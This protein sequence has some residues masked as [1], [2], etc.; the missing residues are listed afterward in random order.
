MIL[1]GSR[2][3]QYYIPDI[4]RI[5]HDW[6]FLMGV[7][8][9]EEFHAKYSKYL[10]KT[11][12][13]IS[14]YEIPDLGIVEISMFRGWQPSDH[15]LLDDGFYNHSTPFG[16]A[17]VPSLNTLYEIKLATE[18]F[19]KE[20]KHLYDLELMEP[21]CVDFT[22]QYTP[23]YQM[24]RN[25]IK[26]RLEQEN[27]VKYDFF[28][29]YHIPEYIKH[30]YLHEVIVDLIDMKLPTYVKI[31]TAETDI[32][33]TLFNKLSYTDK[34]SLMAE[35]SLVLALERWFIPQMIENGINFKLLDIFDNNNEG[36]PTYQIL[37]HCCITGLKGE[38]EYITKFSRDN[39]FAI[40]KLWVDYKHKIK[41]KGG[42]SKDF[43]AILFKLRD[44]YKQGIKIATI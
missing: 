23:L 3:L 19:I 27:K 26:L 22:K 42:F 37:K 43:Y 5:I 35:E 10:I 28:H 41:E 9:F 25:E 8:E 20:P 15:R 4:G 30:D 33:E 36:L 31:T 29:K 14:L 7:T 18:E 34:V 13:H 17:L 38:A 21:H 12:K 32:A 39:F 11:V 6:D 16:N 1:I 24:R 2:A 40:E 44:D